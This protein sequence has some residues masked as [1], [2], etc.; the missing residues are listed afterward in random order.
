MPDRILIRPSEEWLEEVRAYRQEFLDNGDSMD[1]AGPLRRCEDPAAWLAETRLY[2]RPETV[3]EG[4][5][6][7]TQFLCVRPSD[8]RLLGM[9]QVRHRLNDY[10]ARYAGHIG[11]SVRPSER[12]KGTAAWMLREALSYCRALGLDRVV[13]LLGGYPSIRDVIAF[14]KTSSGAD[15]MTEAPGEVSP[16]QLKE[17]NISIRS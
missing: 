12:R 7:A 1:G 10:L 5:V 8:R 17:A 16:R 3:P 4:K 11:Y 9:I 6:Q 14:P 15:P 13:M 2:E